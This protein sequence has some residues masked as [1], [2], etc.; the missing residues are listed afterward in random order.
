MTTLTGAPAR[1]GKGLTPVGEGLWAWLQPNGGWG[2]ANAG[3]VAGD[4]EAL[5]IDTLWDER[6]ARE[7][8]ASMAPALDGRPVRSVF[9]TH[10]D[11]DH[12]WGNGA[13][14]ADAAI[15]TSATSLAVMEEEPGPGELDRLKRVAGMAARVPG[16]LRP[17]GAYVG[18]MLAPFD[19]GGVRERLPDRTFSGEERIDVGG[20]E[21]RL[22]EVGPAH[23]PG[24]AIAHVPDARVVFAADVLFA[25]ATP[26]M[27]AGP[28]DG[29]LSALDR[30]L[31]L[32]A[33]TYVPGHGPPGGTELV[34]EMRDYMSWIGAAVAREHGAGRSPAEAS[35]RLVRSDEF[36]RWRDWDCPE[37]ILITVTA[38]HRALDGKEPV[39]SAPVPRAKL[40][41]EVGRLR[42]ELRG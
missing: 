29:W 25:G 28:V 35:R 6:L 33:E 8:L 17:L 13:L 1:F 7:M 39:G 11:G 15:V 10:S 9:N 24:D 5:L 31:E 20:R 12:W 2:E 18:D 41:R 36:E 3:L 42:D 30:L 40:F 21:V 38:I 14:P 26:V 37:R 22:I 16:P 32:D 27:W 19:F 34:E 4:G 23:T